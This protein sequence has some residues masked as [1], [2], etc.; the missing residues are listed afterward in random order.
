MAVS[1]VDQA[2][3]IERNRAL[4]TQPVAAIAG[5][6]VSSE[7]DASQQI[8][9]NCECSAQHCNATLV[10]PRSDYEHLRPERRQFAVAVDHEVNF[11]P[12]RIILRTETYELV[13][14]W[15]P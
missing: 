2:Y 9:I 14:P 1:T 5:A 6:P 12:I 8:E 13:E 15:R 3:R 7:D 11:A 10:I 4:L